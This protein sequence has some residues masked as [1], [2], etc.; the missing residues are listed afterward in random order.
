MKMHVWIGFLVCAIM[1]I[2]RNAVAGIVPPPELKPGIF[3]YTLPSDFDPPYI[4]KDGVNEIQSSVS[5]LHFP[6]FVVLAEG[7]DASSDEDMAR[8]IDGLAEDWQRLYPAVYK[9]DISQIFL[10]SYRPRKYRFV[11]G[12][13]FK[14]EI[15]FEREAHTPYISIFERYAKGTPRDPK[16]GILNMA[17]DVDGYL[18]DQT[19]PARVAARKIE[20]ERAERARRIALERA[21]KEQR[22]QQARGAIDAEIMRMGELLQKTKYLPPDADAYREALRKAHGVRHADDREAMLR[23][24]AE[25]KPSNDVLEKYIEEHRSQAV[26]GATLTI[27]SWL[28]ILIAL[29]TALKL[30]FF[31][32]LKKL[33]EFRLS[34][35]ESV[36]AWNER[37]KNAA[38]RYIQF[39]GDDRG[40]VVGL[41]ETSG[42]TKRLYEEITK[43]VDDIYAMIHAMEQRID[44]CASRAKKGWFFRLAPL[45]QAVADLDAPF[46]FDTGVLNKAD[47]FGDE[48]KKVVIDP[49]RFVSE[50]SKRYEKSMAGW[51]DL[52][53]AAKLLLYP[54]RER[55]PHAKLDELFALADQF[56]ISKHWLREHPLFGDDESDRQFYETMTDLRDKD[57]LAYLRKTEEI[58]ALERKLEQ[59]LDS[60]V[61]IVKRVRV[62]RLENGPV[63]E[64][65][66]VSVADDPT[67]TFE[68]ARREEDKFFGRLASRDRIEDV[69][70]QARKTI[71]LYRKCTEQ[72]ATIQSAVQDAAQSL[73]RVKESIYKARGLRNSSEDV[74]GKA[75]RV[76]KECKARSFILAGDQY[77]GEAHKLVEEAERRLK[78]AAH[79]DARRMADES[80]SVIKNAER[81]FQEAIKHCSALDLQ[82]EEYE[83]KLASM[84]ERRRSAVEKVRRYG[85]RTSSLREF[86]RPN[87]TGLLDYLV[88]SEVLSSQERA[89]EAT[90][91]DARRAHE[92]EERRH[93]E[94]EAAERRR[95]EEEEDRRSHHSSSSSY[96]SDWGSSSSSSF[97][98]DWGGGSSSSSGGS[99]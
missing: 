78:S 25:L 80:V 98:G 89:W 38:S 86:E 45:S 55:L 96:G 56:G 2:A 51:E 13:K 75:E 26:W 63:L 27:L 87:Q 21:E 20:R 85:G 36:E 69:E 70:E 61:E 3:V 40:D 16:S 65:T 43:E 11:A 91:R 18:F 99:W 46:E 83:R 5:R 74:R 57:P 71:G 19:D 77:L 6:Y 17:I 93:R 14:A 72:Y 59:R 41:A 64:G 97:G 94:E 84:E 9:A 52:K 37:I 4:G 82:K 92:E 1:M 34:I 67:V 31:D 50:M 23:T 76:H 81:K 66:A 48:T 47:L 7:I 68:E 28:A 49:R 73:Q 90:E 62:E 53:R 35:A 58:L 29:F 88:L 24:A 15:G 44:D 60:L 33:R 79:L 32:R 12:S 42:E 39:T 30:F 95:H 10:L 54:A 22:L 8:A